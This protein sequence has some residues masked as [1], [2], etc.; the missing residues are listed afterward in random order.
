M[1]V[2]FLPNLKADII[3]NGVVKRDDAPS[4]G[5]GWSCSVSPLRAPLTAVG[6]MIMAARED[7]QPA[8]LLLIII[9]ARLVV[10]TVM[11]VRTIQLCKAKQVKIDR[12][13]GVLREHLTDPSLKV[14]HMF[15][16]LMPVLMLMSSVD[17]RTE[18]LIERSMAELRRGRT[19]FVIACRLSTVAH[20]PSAVRAPLCRCHP[21]HRQGSIIE[22]G[23]HDALMTDAHMTRQGSS[24]ELY[25]SQFA[26]SPE[27]I[28][29]R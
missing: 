15:A 9:P 6:A 5:W 19:S 7:A 18:V 2:D 27:E 16:L 23:T 20:R 8:R 12:V 10:I 3:N 25:E 4:S 21:H 28:A 22:R 17:T 24:F 1:Q 11:V 26:Q 13:N 14:T 29:A